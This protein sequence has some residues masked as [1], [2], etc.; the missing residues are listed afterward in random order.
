MK[1]ISRASA[2]AKVILFG[3]HFVVYDRLAVVMAID[4]RVHVT[5]KP[6]SDGKIVIGSDVLGCLGAFA[7]DG[8]YRPIKEPHGEARLRPIYMIAKSILASSGRHTGL[9]IL[10]ESTVPIAVGLGSSAAVTVASAAAISSLLELNISK[11]EIFR[12]AF[13]AEKMI[14][15]NPSGIDPAVSTYGGFIAYRRGEGVR[16]LDVDV[17][18]PLV[19]GNTCI[20]RSTG[21]M[22]SLVS[23]IRN[24]YPNIIDRIMDVGEE[25]AKSAIRALENGDINVIG[26]LMNINHALLCAIGVSN[27]AIERLI[28]AAR[29]AGAI[30]AK[31]TGAGGGGCIIALSPPGNLRRVAEAVANAGGESFITN[32]SL[33]GVRVEL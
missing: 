21:E 26:N 29:M 18:L 20:E 33:E 31:L 22:V 14:H 25:V 12:M 2:P 15:G 10:V 17:D 11:D 4:R 9:D 8:D 6:R 32:R 5:V 1:N 3:E 27:E 7:P 13:E 24:L 30:G 23:R 16:R 28:G 19:V